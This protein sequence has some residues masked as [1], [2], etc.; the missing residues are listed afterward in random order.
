M[1]RIENKRTVHPLSASGRGAGGEGR[2]FND[3][4]PHPSPLPLGRAERGLN[5]YEETVELKISLVHDLTICKGTR[6]ESVKY[7]LYIPP[8]AQFS[9]KS[10]ILMS[11]VYAIAYF[12]PI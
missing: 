12:M 5:G 8:F 11:M 4:P 7:F 1:S 9:S 6:G 10:L 2:G 3:L